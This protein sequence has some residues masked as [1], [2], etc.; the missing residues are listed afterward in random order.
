MFRTEVILGQ[1]IDA[2]ADLFMMSFPK[3]IDILRRDHPNF[4]QGRQN[5][6]LEFPVI[7][8]ADLQLDLQ[9]LSLQ[10]GERIPILCP[11]LKTNAFIIDISQSD[12]SVSTLFR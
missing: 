7:G 9:Y 1:A 2:T 4:W 5:G 11:Q 10:L 6:L 8:Q 3:I 12:A